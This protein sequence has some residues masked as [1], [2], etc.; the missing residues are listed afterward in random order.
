MR[1]VAAGTKQSGLFLPAFQCRVGSLNLELRNYSRRA[2][3]LGVYALTCC[4]SAQGIV[5]YFCFV[6]PYKTDANAKT[7]TS[8]K[9]VLVDDSLVWTCPSF[10]L[11]AR[12]SVVMLHA[13]NDGKRSVGRASASDLR[14]HFVIRNFRPYG[15]PA[16]PPHRS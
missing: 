3:E 11:G 10:G 13:R 2:S 14:S 5:V 4:E 6:F 8:S 1:D 7:S 15:S 9:R 16:W 12:S